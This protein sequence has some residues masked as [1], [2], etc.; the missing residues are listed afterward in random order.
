[1]AVHFS[2]AK[3]YKSKLRA[4]Q[5]RELG[6][7]PLS[8]L[9]RITEMEKLADES[10]APSNGVQ[11]GV[12]GEF[13]PPH[14]YGLRGAELSLVQPNKVAVDASIQRIDLADKVGAFDLA[15]DAAESIQARSSVDQMLAHQMAVAHK[16]CM[17][18]LARSVDMADPFQQAKLVNTAARLMDTY[19][20]AMTVI[21]RVGL[22]GKNILAV[23]HVEVHH[24][25]QALVAGSVES[26]RYG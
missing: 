7:L 24:G 19:Q 12:G 16:T 6:D 11:R 20:R 15:L 22:Q 14:E 4:Q 10:L 9:I 25:G 2:N 21:N 1:M 13:V 23:Q 26:N 17:T 5:S 18:L 3:A 8:D